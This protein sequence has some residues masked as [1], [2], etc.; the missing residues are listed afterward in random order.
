MQ[1]SIAEVLDFLKKY[2]FLTLAG[3]LIPL[4]AGARTPT[5]VVAEIA[6]PGESGEL[7]PCRGITVKN[8]SLHISEQLKK[9][10]FNSQEK[11][12]Q[13]YIPE[14]ILR[15]EDVSTLIL[16]RTPQACRLIF[17]KNSGEIPSSWAKHFGK[18]LLRKWQT[19]SDG[20][21]D[22]IGKDKI[23]ISPHTG[24][25]LSLKKNHSWE[26][27]NYGLHQLYQKLPSPAIRE[28]PI[29]SSLRL[30]FAGPGEVMRFL[31]R[32]AQAGSLLIERTPGNM[33]F[34]TMKMGL[35]EESLKSQG[36][37]NIPQGKRVLVE[38][39]YDGSGP[40]DVDVGFLFTPDVPL[41]CRME[42]KNSKEKMV[43]VEITLINPGEDPV[44]INKP[45]AGT[46]TWVRDKQHIMGAHPGRPPSKITLGPGEEVNYVSFFSQEDIPEE[47]RINLGEEYGVIACQ[48]TISR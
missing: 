6:Y 30:H 20:S 41:N 47:A 21:I 14:G 42:I 39:R 8:A 19:H 15:L 34:L 32:P 40:Q 9:N 11:K 43:K 33:P 4:T 23:T 46:I 38:F 13:G 28:V 5:A 27:Y 10:F 1:K 12:P 7:A 17:G 48:P 18:D 35:N 2:F 3:V 26:I 31:L 25:K 22:F 36:M 29:N 44:I 24:K 45:Q 37:I 16:L